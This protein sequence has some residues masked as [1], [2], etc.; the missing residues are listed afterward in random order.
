MQRVADLQNVYM[1]TDSDLDLAL[2]DINKFFALM[3]ITDTFVILPGG[4][5]D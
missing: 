3:V 1:L 4:H 2:K 5:R